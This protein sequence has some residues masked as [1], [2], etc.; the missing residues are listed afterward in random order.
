MHCGCN[1]DIYTC[2]TTDFTCTY[3]PA[4]H[5]E[6]VALR[7]QG[8]TAE[9]IREDFVRQYGEQALMAPKAEGFNLA[10][11]FV[12]GILMLFGIGLLSMWILRRQ[13]QVAALGALARGDAVDGHLGGGR[14]HTGRTRAPPASPVGGEGLMWIE[15]VAAAFVGLSLLWLVF[16]PMFTAA[17]AR[18]A[19]AIDLDSWR[20]SRIPGA[21][22][23][24]RRSRK[25]SSTGKPASSATA[26]TSS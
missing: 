19:D 7:G 26:T 16:E 1:L 25:S 22:W 21:A 24:S 20:T 3:S 6:I 11:Y 13:R 9:Q 5:R 18:P 12:P 2:R 15:V 14:G 17:G 23:R 10:G 4:L 8:K